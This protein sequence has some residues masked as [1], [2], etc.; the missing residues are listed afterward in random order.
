MYEI[1]SEQ[2]NRLWVVVMDEQG[3]EYSGKSNERIHVSHFICGMK[4]LK[5]HVYHWYVTRV[6][7]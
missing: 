1:I 2:N 5:C 4:I 7:K 6:N 3:G